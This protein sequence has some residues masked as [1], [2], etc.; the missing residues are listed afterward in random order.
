[1]TFV[2]TDALC[3]CGSSPLLTLPLYIFPHFLPVFPSSSLCTYFLHIF[4]AKAYRMYVYN[5]KLRRALHVSARYVRWVCFASLAE[6]VSFR[7]QP[8]VLQC[9]T[10]SVAAAIVRLLLSCAS[11]HIRHGGCC[12]LNSWTEAIR[13]C[14]DGISPRTS[15][16]SW[17]RARRGE[18]TTR[19]TRDRAAGRSQASWGASQGGNLR[20]GLRRRRTAMNPIVV[21][22][23]HRVVLCPKPQSSGELRRL[24]S[25]RRLLHPFVVTWATL[26][27]IWVMK[28]QVRASVSPLAQTAKW[29]SNW[30]IAFRT[31]IFLDVYP[32]SGPYYLWGVCIWIAVFLPDFCCICSPRRRGK[33][34]TCPCAGASGRKHQHLCP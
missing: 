3:Y 29:V 14:N 11:C 12:M 27:H 17:R 16:S 20:T 26:I 5:M 13:R 21:F 4:A 32:A 6:Y 25:H 8:D 34:W 2:V 10:S 9:S 18:S 23:L 15:S 24:R 22:N 28:A 7:Q 19:C 31:P 33:T 1:M 30:I